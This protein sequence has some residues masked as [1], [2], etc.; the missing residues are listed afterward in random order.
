M[1][2]VFSF[3]LNNPFRGRSENRP[4]QTQ[5]G[6]AYYAQAKPTKKACPPPA[7]Y[8]HV[9]VYARGYSPRTC[10]LTV[11]IE[12]CFGVTASIENTKDALSAPGAHDREKA[13][14]VTRTQQEDGTAEVR[15]EGVPR[16]RTAVALSLIHI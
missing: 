13:A 16:A 3:N 15:M 14:S 9:Y 11:L 6:A 12:I 10:A 4:K 5:L 7:L 1:N 2:E 8:I